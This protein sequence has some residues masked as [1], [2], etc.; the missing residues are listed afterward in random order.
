MWDTTLRFAACPAS[1]AC[2]SMRKCGYEKSNALRIPKSTRAEI[3]P[4]VIGHSLFFSLL[5]F[6]FATLFSAVFGAVFC[7]RSADHVVG[8]FGGTDA[9][10]WRD[11][12]CQ[13][14]W[15]ERGVFES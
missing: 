14:A 10:V 8:S 4:L 13:A 3:E 11:F 9:D 5:D 2:V 7:G 6:D 12:F 15:G 1:A